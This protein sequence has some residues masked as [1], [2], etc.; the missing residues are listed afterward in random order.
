MKK[1]AIIVLFFSIF[2][3][4]SIL[5][6]QQKCKVLLPAISQTYDG[7]CRKGHAHGKGMATGIDTYKGRFYKGYPNGIGTYTW[8][9]GN[10]YIGEWE[11]GKRNGKGIYKFKYNGK[12]SIQAGVWKDDRYMGP[13]PPPPVILQSRN[14]QNFSF[15][16]YGDQNKLS[17]EIYMNG[18]INST[19]E[20]LVIASTTGSYQTIGKTIVFNGIIY[21]A[22]FK[23]TYKTWNKIHTG[24]Y[25]VTF[26]FTISEPGNWMLKLTN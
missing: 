26:E 10:E 12:D 8:A 6:G 14:I 19:I 23:I 17:I 25:L 4:P 13:V 1:I 11:F 7:K 2:S 21:P 24:Q 15:Q 5:L 9:S 3:I 18:A 22:T 16:K 20:N